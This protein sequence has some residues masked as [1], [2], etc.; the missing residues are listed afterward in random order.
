[1]QPSVI[2]LAR[3]ETVLVDQADYERVSQYRWKLKQ[4]YV[5]HELPRQGNKRT[6]VALARFVMN[7]L[8]KQLVTYLDGD[9]LNMS[10]T[11]LSIWN[12]PVDEKKC[13]VCNEDK[14]ALEFSAHRSICK[15]CRRVEGR[16][17]RNDATRS[18]ERERYAASPDVYK[19]SVKKYNWASRYPDRNSLKRH[20]RRAAVKCA[21]GQL[22]EEEWQSIKDKYGHRCC[23][24][25][26]DGKLTIDHVIPICKGGSLSADNIQPLCRSCN[27]AK[28]ARSDDY[29]N[30]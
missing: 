7:A 20:R 5:V 1:M 17:K 21:E 4:G 29:R 24:C 16:V 6:Y 27:C 22:T 23:K 18:R 9:R 8:P 12:S 19:A 2:S 13:V 30:K 26:A 25:G 10:R 14:A 11:N 3:G 28:G 15:E